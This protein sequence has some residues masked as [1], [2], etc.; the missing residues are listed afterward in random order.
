MRTAIAVLVMTILGAFCAEVQAESDQQTRQEHEAW[1]QRQL[2]QDCPAL[3]TQDAAALAAVQ[4]AHRGERQKVHG[5]ADPYK[6]PWTVLDGLKTRPNPRG[7]GTIVTA[8]EDT[9]RGG[10]ADYSRRRAAWLVLD[11]IV[12][13]LNTDAAGAISHLFDGLPVKIQKRAGLVHSFTPGQTMMDQIGIESYTA[14]RRFSGGNPF[15]QCR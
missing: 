8:W 14:V 1:Y 6:R 12:Y 2:Q 9:N 4:R 13:P 15:P 11:A 7:V 3:K 5:P 10:G